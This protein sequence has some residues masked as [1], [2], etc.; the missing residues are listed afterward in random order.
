MIDLKSV[1]TKICELG[2]FND[3]G[4]SLSVAEAMNEFIGRP[5]ACYVSTGGERAG[6]NRMSTG[7]RQRVMQSVSVLFVMG[8][9]R[10]D[11]DPVD[12]VE[13][14][15]SALILALTAWRP[16]GAD[17]PFDYVGYSFLR[18]EDGLLWGELLFAAPYHIK[19]GP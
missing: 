1:K 8:G 2:I 15:R 6:P 4:D 12:P 5:P 13:E 18:A 19:G 10:R 17:S 16:D 7:H 3:V 9:E 14:I 11:N